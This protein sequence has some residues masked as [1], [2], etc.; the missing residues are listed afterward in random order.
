MS[1]KRI[2]IIGATSAI[3]EHCARLWARE[4]ADFLLVGRDL[5]RIQ[6]VA[7]DLRV[8]SPQSDIQTTQIDFLDVDAIAALA[9]QA[10]QSAIDIVLIAHG[11]LPVQ[12]N[13]EQDLH[14]AQAA[15]QVNGLSPALF[16]EAFAKQLAQQ[17]RGT[18][19]LI[20]S[21]AGDR[22]RKANYVYGAGKGMVER[23]AQGLQHRF[24]TTG[25]KIVL[26][27]PGPTATPMTAHL[28]SGGLAKV[29]QVAHAIIKAIESGNG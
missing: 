9:Q 16:A 14:Q 2:V 1:K 17:G 7:D 4:S 3:A 20:G 8:R 21:V 29:D 26:I 5:A 11:D 15:L 13:C 24:A 10:A 18:L 27:K 19:A 25:I 22:G 23:Y 28:P 6:R 12:Q